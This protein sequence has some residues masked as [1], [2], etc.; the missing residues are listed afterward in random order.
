MP[1]SK[2]SLPRGAANLLAFMTVSCTAVVLLGG[3]SCVTPQSDYDSYIARAADAQGP[4]SSTATAEGGMVDA[5][6]LHA[7]DAAFTDSKYLMAC[8]SQLG[9]E[10]SQALLW[11]ATVQYT[12]A[13]G[14][15]SAMVTYSN[16]PLA[17]TATDVN[18]PIGAAIGPFTA[19]IA[20]DGTGTIKVGHDVLPLEANAI[21]HQD[22]TIENAIIQI[23][24]E[25]DK[26]MCGFLGGDITSPSPLTL[27]PS[28]NPCIFLPTPNG[29]WTAFQTTDFHCP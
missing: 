11:V 9:Q 4:P 18:S 24:V 3:T 10:A 27:D 7:P 1:M 5:A 14:G 6:N 13:T 25:A 20:P 29:S 8:L 22:V 15:K 12:P 26:T 2:R 21:T 17:A 19:S 23:R 28:Q 16:Q